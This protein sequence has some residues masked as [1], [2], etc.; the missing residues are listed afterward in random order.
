MN[1]EISFALISVAALLCVTS[2]TFDGQSY[3]MNPGAWRFRVFIFTSVVSIL[4]S[5]LLLMAHAS[6]IHRMMP[7]DWLLLD[8]GISGVLTF[9]YLVT[10]AMIGAV[11]HEYSN[12]LRVWLDRNILLAGMGYET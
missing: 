7:I 9:L 6:T 10:T 2:T 11:Y 1:Y 3:L 12:K 5:F 8:I 4:T